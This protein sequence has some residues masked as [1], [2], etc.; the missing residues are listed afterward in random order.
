MQ[1]RNPEA[2]EARLRAGCRKTETPKHRN[3]HTTAST[4]GCEVVVTQVI[5]PAYITYYAFSKTLVLYEHLNLFVRNLTEALA[6]ARQS[7]LELQAT[8]ALLEKRVEERTHD[9]ARRARY[10]EATAAIA[11]EA[12]SELELGG[13]I[14]SVANSIS[15]QFGFYHTGIFLLDSAR[16][17][18][19]LKAAS[20]EGGQRLRARG[21]RL[22]V[23]QDGMVGYVAQRGEPRTALDTGKDA[24]FFSN[25]DLPQTRSEAA[26][27]LRA[28]GQVIGVLDVQSTEPEVFTQEDVTVLQTLADQIATAI[29]NARLFRQVEESVQAERRAYGEL[30]GQAWAD[31]L[32][33]R[34]GL[35]F[36]SNR[37]TVAPAGDVWTPHMQTALESGQTVSGQDA[38]TVAIPIKVRDRVIGVIDGRKRDGRGQWTPEEL[39]L[40]QTLA[41]QSAVALESARLYQDTQRRAARE[42]LTGQVTARVRESLDLDT[43]LQTVVREL[44]ETLNLAEARVRLGTGPQHPSQERRQA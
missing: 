27:P 28:R 13:L 37:Q 29:N 43:V 30:A 33:A 15:R 17:W 21:F 31:L 18:A 16:E 2:P 39:A 9:L 34:T 38:A 22:R 25:P 8:R 44:G 24:V 23:G 6:Q 4:D 14:T 11:R 10:L 3:T 7:N 1:S 41:E 40:I 26:L 35:G 5:G 32:R 12:T 36:V 42:Q 20:S 19:E